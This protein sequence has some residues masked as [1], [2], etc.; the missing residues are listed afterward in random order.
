MFA[1]G[2]ISVCGVICEINNLELTNQIAK[3]H[4]KKKIIY[5]YILILYSIAVD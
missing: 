1:A 2:V 5:I 3:F 4:Y